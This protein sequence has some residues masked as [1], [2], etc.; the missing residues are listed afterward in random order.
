MYTIRTIMPP[1]LSTKIDMDRG[2]AKK[3]S[4]PDMMDALP[5]GM[6]K[7]ES[8]D[9]N[10]GKIREDSLQKQ[11]METLTSRAK[12]MGKTTGGSSKGRSSAPQN[13]Y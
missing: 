1:S 12:P 2:Y 7:S 4:L 10:L 5:A 13:Q 6:L 3:S 9:V 11:S 8:P